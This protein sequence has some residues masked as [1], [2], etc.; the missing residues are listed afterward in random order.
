[1]HPR[2]WSEYSFHG[3][4][5]YSF[6][7]YAGEMEITRNVGGPSGLYNNDRHGTISLEFS[8]LSASPKRTQKWLSS[9]SIRGS[10]P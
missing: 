4:I 10:L 6:W 1:M 5:L 9:K 8:D 3:F 7:S 2:L